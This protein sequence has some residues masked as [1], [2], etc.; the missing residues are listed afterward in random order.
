MVDFH[1][2]KKKKKKKICAIKYSE[3]YKN[4]S[5]KEALKKVVM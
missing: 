1:P 4:K 3:P 5:L 2:N